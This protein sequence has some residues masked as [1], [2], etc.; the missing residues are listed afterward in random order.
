MRITIRALKALIR[1]SNALPGGQG[2]H[3]SS[4]DV[5]PHELKKGIAHEM[6]HTFDK[7]IA[8]EIALD[9]LAED[10]AY[11]TNLEH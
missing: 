7:S 3:L 11:Y 1:E 10:P 2:D 8:L 4:D 9:H 5:D 6:E